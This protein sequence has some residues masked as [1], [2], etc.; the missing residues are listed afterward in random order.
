MD[1]FF[2]QQLVH[3]G[4]DVAKDWLATD[5]KNIFEHEVVLIPIHEA[6]HWTLIAILVKLKSIIYLDSLGQPNRYGHK[7]IN[8]FLNFPKFFS[9]I[10]NPDFTKSST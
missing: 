2:Y 6:K 7:F 10:S 9:K 1:T 3:E 8:F 4:Y 5:K